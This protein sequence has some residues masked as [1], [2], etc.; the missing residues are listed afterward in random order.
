MIY[1]CS[2]IFMITGF[3]LDKRKLDIWLGETKVIP[4]MKN[5]SSYPFPSESIE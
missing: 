3:S 2:K 1:S 5:M 4:I